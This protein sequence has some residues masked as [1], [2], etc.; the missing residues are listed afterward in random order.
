ML[1]QVVIEIYSGVIDEVTVFQFKE[2]A[3]K[4]YADNDGP[5]NEKL[6]PN[7]SNFEIKW[8]QDIE[9]K[10]MPVGWDSKAN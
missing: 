6:D 3:A 1:V 10:C 9:V 7:S 5:E 8:F 4:Y 2:D